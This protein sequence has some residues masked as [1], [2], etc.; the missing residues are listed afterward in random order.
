M[1][2]SGLCCG[3]ATQAPLADA[4]TS[5][6]G[7]CLQAEVER[8]RAANAA[9]QEKMQREER[10]RSAESAKS[11]GNA[12]FQAQQFEEALQHYS[13]ALETLASS[14][15]IGGGAGGSGSSS[16][17]SIDAALAA[18]LH[19]NRA[20]AHQACGRYLHA[21][22]DCFR[23]EA[24]DP[25]YSRIFHR[26]ADAHWAIGAWDAAAQVGIPR[27]DLPRA[28]KHGSQGDADCLT[29]TLLL[30]FCRTWAAC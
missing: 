15:G 2:F 19:C 14:G 21:L 7:K 13:R 17:K 27:N 16:S 18:V 24:L 11:A 12:A 28:S 23:A 29:L 9:A 22:A 26:R 1:H 10:R 30:V 20:A 6:C 25:S 8:L 4:E 3:T 5:G